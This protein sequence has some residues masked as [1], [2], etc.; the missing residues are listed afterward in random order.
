MEGTDYANTGPPPMDPSALAAAQHLE[1]LQAHPIPH[2]QLQT[3]HMEHHHH[4]H[5]HQATLEHH[6]QQHPQ[7]MDPGRAQGLEHTHPHVMDHAQVYDPTHQQVPDH[8][9]PHQHVH[10][11]H[12]HPPEDYYHMPD[13]SAPMAQPMDDPGAAGADGVDPDGQGANG[14]KPLTSRYRSVTHYLAAI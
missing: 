12:G 5:H 14:E 11:T 8:G 10:Q 9:H 13:G 7:V 6:H 2:E 1:A 3:A 4:H